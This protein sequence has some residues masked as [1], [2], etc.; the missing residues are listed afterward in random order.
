M[1]SSLKSQGTWK[2]RGIVDADKNGSITKAELKKLFE[3]LGCPISSEELDQVFKELDEDGS[4][5]V[6][7]KE[8]TKWYIRSEQRMRHRTREVFDKFDKNNS[9]TIEFPEVESVM[10]ELD[11]LVTDADVQKAINEMNQDD[12]E[13]ITY[14]EFE[15]WYMKSFI[16][17]NHHKTLEN[18]SLEG[19][20]ENFSPPPLKNGVFAV[21]SWLVVLPLIATLSL[22]IP[23]VRMTRFQKGPWCYLSFVIS[24]AWVGIYSFFMVDWATIIGDTI[25]IPSVIMGLTFLAA[26]TSVPDLLSSVI[27]A[28]RGQGDMAV[29]SSI[30]SNIFDITV[31]LPLPWLIYTLMPDN[32][33]VEIASGGVFQ[34]VLILLG[35]VVLIILTIHLSGWKLSKSVGGIMF[36]LY[37]AFLG[38]GVWQEYPFEDACG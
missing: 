3:G 30:G 16:Y 27:V 24:I 12:E 28:K 20:F 5:G 14:E 38:Q 9:G 7:K 18:T 33:Y 2:N 17:Q 11:P 35:M 37:F 19:I 13:E 26:G 22:T 29:S 25:G 32:K 34:S 10:K 15:S 8:F 21:I 36:L 1:E 6:S 23:D 4:G 31:G